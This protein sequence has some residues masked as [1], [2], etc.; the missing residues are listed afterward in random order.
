MTWSRAIPVLVVAFIFDALRFLF[1]MFWFFG[2]AIA[3]LYCTSAA[4]SALGTSVAGVAGKVVAVGCSAVAGVAGYFAAPALIMFGVIMAM[5]IGLMGWMTIGFI[6]LMTNPRILKGTGGNAV[7]FIVSLLISELPL[8]D[9][10]P[11]LTGT[12]FRMYSV[13]IKNEAHAQQAYEKAHAEEQL[14]ERNQHRAQL[15]QARDAQMTQLQEQEAI[16]EQESEED[17]LIEQGPMATE[18]DNDVSYT[19]EMKKVA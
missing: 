14:Q 7:W 5:A 8:I 17:S 15:T 10:V 11:A 13:Q 16:Y 19:P 4:N 1:D 3:A 9:A 18:A 2:P 6:I 12:L